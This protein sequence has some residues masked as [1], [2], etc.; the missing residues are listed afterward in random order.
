[1][2]PKRYFVFGC[3]T[4]LI[5]GGVLASQNTQP[6]I[7]LSSGS[8]MG[9]SQAVSVSIAMQA[10]TAA[11]EIP[12][13]VKP[14]QKIPEKQPTPS[15]TEPSVTKTV[16]KAKPQKL[17]P[18]KVKPAAAKPSPKATQIAE[19][20]PQAVEKTVS[21]PV[22]KDIPP[23]VIDE[24]TT[25]VAKT[26]SHN[27]NQA[28]AKQGVTQ[29]SVALNQPTFAA[30]PSQ[31]HY[32]KKARKRGF[33]GTATVEVMF[34]QVGEQLSL[35]LVNSS[36]YRLLDKAALSAV[37]KWQFAAPTP[38]TAYAYT[39]RVPVKFALN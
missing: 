14:Q 4:V 31:P 33:Q 37:E 16:A 12:E 36:G 9:S 10:S 22:E 2:T 24:P 35:T 1:M 29:Q 23:K 8:A 13:P 25:E 17:V 19:H 34:N 30:P 18:K 20:K 6:E 26:P 39:V 38:Q 7:A 21:K 32:P 11:A 15:V 27:Q 28:D 3:L 5:Q